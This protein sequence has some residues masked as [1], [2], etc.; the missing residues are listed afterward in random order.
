MNI[1]ARLQQG[2]PSKEEITRFLPVKLILV[3]V[4]SVGFLILGWYGFPSFRPHMIAIG[5]ALG[6]MFSAI[7]GLISENEKM[8]VKWFYA[9][10]GSL[11]VGGV[12]W[13]TTF[14]LSNQL[15]VKREEAASLQSRYHMLNADLRR[16]ARA[17]GDQM[18][19]EAARM[20]NAEWRDNILAKPPDQRDYTHNDELIRFISDL[21]PTNGHALY[22]R[23]ETKRKKKTP[24]GSQEDF[25]RYLE[26]E[27]SLPEE[28]KGGSTQQSVCTARPK[29]YCKQRTAWI[30]HLLA[31]DFEKKGRQE[32]ER[33]KKRAAFQTALNYAKA[34]LANYPGGFY[35]DGQGST[36]V[37]EQELI[38]ELDQISGTQQ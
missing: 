16:Y 3:I 23:G 14:D 1:V 32:T 28:E 31:S 27:A 12:T 34:A 8:K 20:L 7:P 26:I 36:K 2:L 22:F 37:M 21:D 5:T 11:I 4:I 10:L 19:L 35:G 17:T 9:V 38:K 30:E 6:A 33:E 13:Y 24:G 18:I 29:G 15:E 25:M